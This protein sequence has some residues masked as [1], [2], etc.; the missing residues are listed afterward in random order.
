MKRAKD[1]I[2]SKDEANV[3]SKMG[4]DALNKEIEEARDKIAEDLE[5]MNLSSSARPR[6]R[7]TDVSYEHCGIITD[8]F[9]LLEMELLWLLN[10]TLMLNLLHL[11]KKRRAR[12]GPPRY[13]ILFN[14]EFFNVYHK[15]NRQ[16][17]I[18]R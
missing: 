8:Y 6:G 13:L 9:R 7:A 10:G 18:R 11:Q 2:L 14:F 1:Y 12:Q 3:L 15:E 4:E 17:C 5:R 16:S